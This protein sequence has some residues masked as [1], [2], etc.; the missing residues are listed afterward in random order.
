M[1]RMMILLSMMFAVPSLAQAQLP[2]VD[3]VPVG[4]QVTYNLGDT[5]PQS[6]MIEFPD[7]AAL[8]GEVLWGKLRIFARF[9]YA[10][11]TASA[12]IFEAT[13]P[14]QVRITFPFTEHGTVISGAFL[15]KDETGETRLY[16]PGDS[17]LIRQGSVVVW[18]MLT[19]RMQK[20]FFN[21]LETP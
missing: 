16:L 8:G 12:G 17:Y 10:T 11:P 5:I 14:S 13:G 2:P 18:T 4:E 20:S 21:M 1:R 3:N 19:P 6:E 9:D 15:M 7:P